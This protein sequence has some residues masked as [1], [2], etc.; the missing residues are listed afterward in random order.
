MAKKSKDKVS[1]ECQFFDVPRY[2]G[3][4]K[5]KT[6]VEKWCFVHA[7]WNCKDGIIKT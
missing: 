5:T 6:K 2:T 4:N 1:K 3:P 7:Q